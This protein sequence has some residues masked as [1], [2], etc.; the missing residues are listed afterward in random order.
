MTLFAFLCYV[1]F[2]IIALILY[3]RNFIICDDL[4][5]SRPRTLIP[6]NT[7]KNMFY[8]VDE[9]WV[10]T[11]DHSRLHA[12][13]IYQPDPLPKTTMLYCHGNSGSILTT[14]NKLHAFYTKL[15]LNLVVFDYHGF[16]QSTGYCQ[17]EQT[18]VDDACVIYNRCIV[19]NPRLQHTAV[20]LYGVSLGGYAVL[21]LCSNPDVVIQSIVLENT[22]FSLDHVLQRSSL[23]KWIPSCWYFLHVS[24]ESWMYQIPTNTPILFISSKHDP[25]LSY[26]NTIGL[27]HIA[28][29][30]DMKHVHCLLFSDPSIGHINAW[31]S[32][33]SH[34]FFSEIQ[35]FI[36]KYSMF[37]V[38]NVF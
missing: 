7:W 26:S 20:T 32:L 23:F 19:E 5:I 31:K 29:K 13:I 11:P 15:H 8:H 22:L 24:N 38:K 18:L 34:V 36:E 10:E 6:L 28:L 9:V 35:H 3:Q 16:G 33:Q 17:N 37:K 27:H 4:I 2:V 25:I 1:T 30:R 12:W 14:M 21:G